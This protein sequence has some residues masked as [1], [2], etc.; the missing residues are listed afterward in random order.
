MALA[1]KLA[2]KKPRTAADHYDLWLKALPDT[3]RAAVINALVRDDHT[4]REL[5]T[6]LE[7][8]E[9]NPAPTYGVTAF[10]EW[11]STK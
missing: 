10:R 1:D 7:S 6:I 11:R 3:E 4:H 9:D 8:D 2:A 5:K